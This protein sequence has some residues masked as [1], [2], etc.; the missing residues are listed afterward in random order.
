MLGRSI[1]ARNTCG[2]PNTATTGAV[3]G[4]P[5]V[6][7][8]DILRPSIG[9]VTLQWWLDGAPIPGANADSYTYT[10]VAPSAPTRTLQLRATDQTPLVH[11]DM[12]G[13]LL[14]HTRTWTLQVSAGEMFR[15][16][17]E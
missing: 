8:A 12:A 5:Q 3:F 17:F 2:V 9:S 14:E 15:N 16:G 10:P 4:T 13:G 6:F 11:P 7:H 1:S